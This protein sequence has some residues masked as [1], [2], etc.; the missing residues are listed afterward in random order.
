[1]IALL[2]ACQEAPKDHASPPDFQESAPDIPWILSG[3]TTTALDLDGVLASA[4][5]GIALVAEMEPDPVLDAY[6]D[7]AASA[8]A[9]CPAVYSDDDLDYWL[10]TC[11]SAD[12]TLFDGFALDDQVYVDDGYSTYEV[13]ATGGSGRIE[14]ADG[15]FVEVDGYV[16]RIDDED[17][18]VIS[19]T[20]VL[21]GDFATNHP[22][23]D[24]TWVGNGVRPNLVVTRYSIL[25]NVVLIGATGAVDRVPGPNPSVAFDGAAILD[26]SIGYGGCE[27]EPSGAV[28][29]RLPSGD[30]V[31]IVFEPV[32]ADDGGVTVEDPADCDGCGQAWHRAEALGEVCLDFSSW[33]G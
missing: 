8:D 26:P 32:L 27:L 29:V 13:T 7:L 18:G 4:Q 20:L 6:R 19:T 5:S 10:D 12:G 14:S 16:Q 30:W 23:A 17:N 15:T 22:A 2:A 31:D 24:G 33:L 25:G 11:T 3:T 21:S 28:S 1:V 9:D